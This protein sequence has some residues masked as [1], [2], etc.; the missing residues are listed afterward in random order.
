MKL[1]VEKY[2]F[3]RAQGSNSR[4]ADIT[5]EQVLAGDFPWAFRGIPE[6]AAGELLVTQCDAVVVVSTVGL[7]GDTLVWLSV[8]TLCYQG[9][10][11]VWQVT[12]NL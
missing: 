3:I 8:I 12:M 2:N 5:A 11:A 6:D 10:H 7:A 1:L 4:P 9:M